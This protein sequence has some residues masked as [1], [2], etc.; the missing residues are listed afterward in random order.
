MVPVVGLEPT[1]RLLNPLILLRLL[2]W[3][4]RS[5]PAK[6]L[7][8]LVQF[9]N[10]I[11]FGK[12]AID[13]VRGGDGCVAYLISYGEVLNAEMETEGNVTMAQTMKADTWQIIFPT[14]GV[15]LRV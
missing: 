15:D 5:T 10:S 6:M 9:A 7:L 12:M 14:D 1:Y 4:A 8:H 2:I 13:V 11:F 3:Y